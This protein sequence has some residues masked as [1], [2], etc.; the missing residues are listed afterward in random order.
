MPIIDL[1]RKCVICRE[2]VLCDSD[3]EI[4]IFIDEGTK[5]SDI[6]RAKQEFRN[7]QQLTI[8]TNT[9]KQHKKITDLA[10]KFCKDH[11]IEAT[12]KEGITVK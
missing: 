11:F 1:R 4:L 9:E 2:I 10:Q 3:K 8:E 7:M 5:Q 12:K 6:N